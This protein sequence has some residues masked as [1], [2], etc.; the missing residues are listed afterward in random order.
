VAIVPIF[1]QDNKQ[2][3]LY[4]RKSRSLYDPMIYVITFG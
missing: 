1:N 4:N 3:K 2:N